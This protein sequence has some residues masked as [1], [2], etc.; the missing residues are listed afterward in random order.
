MMWWDKEI[1]KRLEAIGLTPLMYQR[2]VDDI[3][4]VSQSHLLDLDMRMGLGTLMQHALI[5]TSPE[6]EYNRMVVF[7]TDVPQTIYN[8]INYHKHKLQ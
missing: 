7:A 4:T 5:G 3:N 2:Y 6:K 1:K 8:V